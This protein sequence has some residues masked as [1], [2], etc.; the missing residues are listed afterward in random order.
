MTLIGAPELLAEQ[1]SRYRSGGSRFGP[2]AISLGIEA[3]VAVVLIY[4][5][6]GPGAMPRGPTTLVSV[7]LDRP[8]EPQPEVQPKRQQAGAAPDR[9]AA[10]PAGRKAQASPIIAA[11]Q[12]L[13]I[14]TPPPAAQTPGTSVGISAVRI[15]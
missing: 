9:G 5:L 15:L 6:V 14:P 13:P 4:G 7:G 2:A 12:P 11:P 10:A 3:L 1:P 8:P